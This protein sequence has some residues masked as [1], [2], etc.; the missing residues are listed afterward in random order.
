M[1]YFFNLIKSSVYYDIEKIPNGL[2]SDFR[3]YQRC[4]RWL[5]FLI[6]APIS[7]IMWLVLRILSRKYKISIYVLPT[8]RPGIASMYLSTIEPLCRELQY[9]NDPKHFTILVNPQEEISEV[10]TKSY[11]PHFSFYLDDRRKFARLVAYLIPQKGLQ[12]LYLTGKREFDSGWV[13]PPSKN[14]VRRGIGVPN[15][16]KKLGIEKENYVLFVHPSSN[17]YQKRFPKSVVT[18][19]PHTNIGLS[20]YEQPLFA[21]VKQGVQIVR[22]GTHV[23]DLPNSFVNFPIIDY[24]RGKRD[25]VSELWLYENCKFLI[26]VAA[27]GAFWFSRRFNRPT[28]ITDSFRFVN[29]YFSTFYTPYLLKDIRTDELL[30]FRQMR[31]FNLDHALNDADTMLSNGVQII[32]NSPSTLTSSIIETLDYA[33][34]LIHLDSTDKE[35]LDKYNSFCQEFGFVF[36]ENTTRPTLSFLREYSHLLD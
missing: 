30:S 21:L 17:Y 13:Y 26:S 20:N 4:L 12:K 34:G 28:I 31:Q 2:T 35:L 36:N 10:L 1:K 29:R 19:F 15:D 22:V 3:R 24:V 33:N 27:N 9:S 25:E 16:L 7:L 18:S 11:E 8:F 5:L 6:A 32:Q 14:Y 23:D